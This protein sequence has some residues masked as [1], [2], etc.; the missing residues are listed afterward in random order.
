[1]IWKKCGHALWFIPY[2]PYDMVNYISYVVNAKLVKGGS[3]EETADR[4]S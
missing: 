1:M 2:G 3:I 4:F